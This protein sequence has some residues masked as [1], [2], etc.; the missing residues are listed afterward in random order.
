MSNS[1]VT[2]MEVYSDASNV[3]LSHD[4]TLAISVLYFFSEVSLDTFYM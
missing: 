3:N 4:M 1:L 2:S